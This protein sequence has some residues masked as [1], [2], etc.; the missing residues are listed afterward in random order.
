M[1]APTPDPNRTNLLT[2]WWTFV[3]RHR[4]LWLLPIIALVLTITLLIWL[5]SDAAAPLIYSLF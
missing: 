2:E 3:Q 5:T 1:N 4:N